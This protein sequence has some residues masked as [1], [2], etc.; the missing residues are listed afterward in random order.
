MI[1]ETPKGTTVY[2]NV[3]RADPTVLKSLRLHQDEFKGNELK[4]SD[5]RWP[6]ILEAMSNGSIALRVFW[7]RE[8]PP[9]TS[10]WYELDPRSEFKSP[11]RPPNKAWLAY[12]SKGH[13][14]VASERF[15]TVVRDNKLTGASFLQLETPTPTGI[16]QW[17]EVFATH[18]LGRGIDHPLLD[19]ALYERECLRDFSHVA[20]RRLR[21]GE[22]QFARAVF[23]QDVTYTDAVFGVLINHRCSEESQLFAS[24][25][26]GCAHFAMEYAPSTDFAYVGWPMNPI[27]DSDPPPRWRSLAC[28][29]RAREALLA[30]GVMTPGEFVPYVM[31]SADEARGTVCDRQTLEPLPLPSFTPDEYTAES[32][33][34][35]M[36]H[37]AKPAVNAPRAPKTVTELINLLEASSTRLGWK[38]LSSTRA[39]AVIQQ[40]DL[41]ALLP[42]NWREL[43][44]HVPAEITD[45]T[46]DAPVPDCEI[47]VPAWNTTVDDDSSRAKSTTPSS[48]DLI[49]AQTGF[50]DWFSVRLTKDKPPRDAKVTHWDHETLSPA[51]SWPSTIAF[52]HDLMLAAENAAK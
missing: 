17:Y 8:P 40:S 27:I 49:I 30:A 4:L 35:V 21:Q 14:M 6:A 1:Y 42:T 36:M 51:Q 32:A 2:F 31:V 39:Y 28:S 12:Q 16:E 26:A 34:R 44:P 33:R 19:S 7:F 15:M 11:A 45:E 13:R 48:R 25:S 9:L 24:G 22:Q 29:H 37:V 20:L 23:R 5:R 10:T 18:P 47:A 52:A 46:D 50:G 38:P 43:L 41:Y 3:E